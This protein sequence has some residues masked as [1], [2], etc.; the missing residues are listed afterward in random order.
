M[1]KRKIGGKYVRLASADG[2]YGREDAG[3]KRTIGSDEAGVK[4]EFVGSKTREFTFSNRTYGTHTITAE[5]F[6]EALRIA[7]SMG[8]SR[9]DYKK[10]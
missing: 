10:R 1:I 3:I 2:Y 4:R 7:E 9:G 8:F 6:E 5:S